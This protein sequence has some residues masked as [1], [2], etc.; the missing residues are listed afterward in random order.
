MPFAEETTPSALNGLG[1]SYKLN[2]C[3]PPKCV[4]EALSPSMMV[5]K[6]GLWE[7]IRV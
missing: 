4:I 5:R 3:I 6:W 7:V 1:T 2:V